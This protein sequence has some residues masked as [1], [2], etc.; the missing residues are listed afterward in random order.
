MAT[1]TTACIRCTSPLAE[2]H[3]RE[4]YHHTPEQLHAA[5]KQAGVIMDD[6]ELTELERAHLGPTLV[7]LLSSKQIFYEQVGPLPDL[8]N[9]KA[10]RH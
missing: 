5:V 8:G 9:L 7:T 2:M 4:D 3:K 1:R 10:A 6:F